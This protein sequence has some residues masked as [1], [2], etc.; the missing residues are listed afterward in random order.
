MQ[1][2]LDL[3]GRV[4]LVTGASSGIGAATAMTLADLGAPRRDWRITATRRARKR[5]GI[6]SSRPA[7]A[8]LRS[9]RTSGAPTR[10]ARSS[11]ARDGRARAD[12]HP[13]QQRRLA[14]DAAQH[15]RDHRSAA[16]R[17]LGAEPEERGA[18]VA[19]GGG[20]DD[21]AKARRDRQRRV[22]C[23]AHRRRAGSR[24]VRVG[25]SGADVAH[26]VAREGACAARH[27]GERGLPG[28]HRHAVSRDVLDA[29]DDALVRGRDSDG[30]GRHRGRVRAR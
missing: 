17:H 3:T 20:R 19:G 14:R 5:R 21:R 9:R 10:S 11:T 12:R 15:P 8:R 2:L 6:G 28:R 27:P 30:A 26:Q 25:E 29:R 7:A 1:Q 18:R 24:G 23:R 13:R 16:R 22:D 4:A